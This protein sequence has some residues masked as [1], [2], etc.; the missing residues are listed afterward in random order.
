MSVKLLKLTTGEEV[1]A[2]V[3]SDIGSEVVVTDAVIVY[4]A[5]N[6]QGGL[7]LQF[8]PWTLT[9]FSE[10]GKATI[11]ADGIIGGCEVNTEILKK[12]NDMFGN[13]SI[14]VPEKKIIL[15]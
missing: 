6:E 1:L 11:H 3:L 4:P 8:A 2:T 15:S 7:S 5:Q 13:V 9:M 10:D 12:Y 14:A